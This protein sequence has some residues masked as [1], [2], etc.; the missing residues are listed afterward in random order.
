MSDESND[1]AKV[2]VKAVKDRLHA[3]IKQEREMYP[4]RR[5]T[6]FI[7]SITDKEAEALI[8]KEDDA[9]ADK[10]P[11]PST[12]KKDD[13]DEGGDDDEEDERRGQHIPLGRVIEKTMQ[14]KPKAASSSKKKKKSSPP[15]PSSSSRNKKKRK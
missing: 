13:D 9:A 10:E 14:T 15:P 3:Q 8:G 1:K 4:H 11:E 2:D 6:D 12:D 5:D 7:L